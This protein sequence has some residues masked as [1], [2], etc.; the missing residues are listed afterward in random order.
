M[1]D[2]LV[3]SEKALPATR[4][5]YSSWNYNWIFS[6]SYFFSMWI[7]QIANLPGWR[8][9]ARYFI[10]IPFPSFSSIVS[11]TTPRSISNLLVCVEMEFFGFISGKPTGGK[12]PTALTTDSRIYHIPITSSWFRPL[13]SSPRNCSEFLIGKTEESLLPESIGV[14]I[15]YD[16]L[17]QKHT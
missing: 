2:W 16:P 3:T 15:Y 9:F 7:L 8:V 6:K 5:K 13:V 14:A 12:N 17:K 1:P 10:E 11:W 4:L